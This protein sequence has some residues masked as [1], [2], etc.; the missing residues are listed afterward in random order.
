[1]GF[2]IDAAELKIA[3]G[4]DGIAMI[5]PDTVDVENSVALLFVTNGLLFESGEFAGEFVSDPDWFGKESMLNE[6][7]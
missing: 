3:L 5:W 2:C 4:S 1:M 6:K 7:C